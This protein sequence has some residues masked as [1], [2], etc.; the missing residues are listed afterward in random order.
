MKLKI[1]WLGMVKHHVSYKPERVIYLTKK[2]HFHRHFYSRCDICKRRVLSRLYF[3]PIDYFTGLSY[4]DKVVNPNT[5]NIVAPWPKRGRWV[6]ICDD[7]KP[8]TLGLVITPPSGK[9]NVL[10]ESYIRWI[11]KKNNIDVE[12]AKRRWIEK[13][14]QAQRE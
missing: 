14:A 12:E 2:E 1:E 7:C 5:G 10:S 3:A 8:K 11:Q 4:Y 13:K 6:H 9:R